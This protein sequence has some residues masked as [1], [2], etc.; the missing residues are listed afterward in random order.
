MDENDIY[1]HTPDVSKPFY[2]GKDNSFYERIKL[3]IEGGG[4][5]SFDIKDSKLCIPVNNVDKKAMQLIE[6]LAH[7]P[8]MDSPTLHEILEVLHFAQVWIE[9]LQII[10]YNATTGKV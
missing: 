6:Q 2:D 4:G 7:D 1:T 9:L 5:L 3:A 10:E 8:E